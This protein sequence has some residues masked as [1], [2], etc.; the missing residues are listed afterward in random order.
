MVLSCSE[1]QTVI[2]FAQTSS[3]SGFKTKKLSFSLHHLLP[4]GCV[5]N[6]LV[7]FELV[8][9]HLEELIGVGAQVLH[10]AHE[11]LDR[12]LHHHRALEVEM[13]RQ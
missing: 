3:C 2:F 5:A 8:A 12:L 10:Q 11:I 13:R 6:V 7:L 9:N 4:V 1:T